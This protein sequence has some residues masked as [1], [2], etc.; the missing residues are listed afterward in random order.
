MSVNSQSTR[1]TN[2]PEL[3]FVLPCLNEE[4]TIGACVAQCF[5]TLKTAA[6]EGEVVVA[7]NGSTDKSPQ[8]AS[9]FG[10]TVVFV[11]QKGYG[12]ALRGGIASA[13]GKYVIIGDSDMSYDFSQMPR[14]LRQ[15]R[16][17]YDLVMGCRMPQGGGTIEPGAMPF[18]HRWFGNPLLS[19]LGRLLF[20]AN[21]V[22][23]HCGIRAFN[24]ERILQLALQ[25]PGMEFASEMIVKAVLARYR[26]AQVPV[27]LQADQRGQSP[28]LR[29]WSDGWRHLRFMLLHAP[30]WLFFYPGLGVTCFCASIFA[31]LLFGPIRIFGIRFDTN[32]LLMAALGILV[33]FQISLMGLFSEVFS[34]RIGLL[35][36]N[37]LTQYVLTGRLF[38]KGVRFGTVL[39]LAGLLCL[40]LACAKWRKTGFADL[41][42]PDTLRLTIPAMTAMSIGIQMIFGSFLVSV[43]GLPTSISDSVQ[44]EMNDP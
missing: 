22:D 35:P 33:G 16:A 4:K 2:S 38:L 43:L 23:F 31:A 6:I 20:R 39:F 27:T 29:T 26:I 44:T 40:W 18:L 9:S 12:S 24:R 30:R 19:G 17:G 28:H 15:L 41:T 5:E 25:T 8:I 13:K 11:D 34:R 7:D 37:R 3:S 32:T 14:F 36:A 1:S 21:I 42:Y 10:A